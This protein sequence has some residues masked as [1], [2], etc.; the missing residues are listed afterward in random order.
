MSI[1][2]FHLLGLVTALIVAAPLAA[3]AADGK[4]LQWSPPSTPSAN[5]SAE[6]AA[7]LARQAAEL[8]QRAAQMA[9]A[10]KNSPSANTDA[11]IPTALQQ[12]NVVDIRFENSAPKVSDAPPAS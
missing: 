11:P 7:Q 6:E 12:P 4:T 5:G 10:A 2:T 9:A 3:H 1:R 8:A